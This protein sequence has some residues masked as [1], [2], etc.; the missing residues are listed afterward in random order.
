MK[1]VG[2]RKGRQA[3]YIRPDDKKSGS[4]LKPGQDIWKNS[5]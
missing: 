1:F 3:S 4:E 2:D 5:N